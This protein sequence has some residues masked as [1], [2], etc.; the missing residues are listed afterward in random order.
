VYFL[1]FVDDGGRKPHWIFTGLLVPL[2][3]HR[4]F[5]AHWLKG[6]R[7]L[8][9]RWGVPVDAEIKANELVVTRGR[10]SVS[11]HPHPL[12][13]LFDRLEAYR[14]M[15]TAVADC[16]TLRVLVTTRYDDG[17][18]HDSKTSPRDLAYAEFLRRL[19]GWAER[20]RASVILIY[21]GGP[22]PRVADDTTEEE[23]LREW[24]RYNNTRPLRD[25]YEHLRSEM[26]VLR[27]G[28]PVI[29]DML[30][31]ESA[32]SPLIQAADFVSFAAFQHV[33]QAHGGSP[34]KSA[35]QE[36]L[37]QYRRKIAALYRSSMQDRWLPDDDHGIHWVGYP[38]QKPSG[39]T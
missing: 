31:Q 1:C 22:P 33:R 37:E 21:D 11:T 3:D 10:P 36:R 8:A 38:I 39:S 15:L 24:R 4:T 17:R 9:N 26:A 34:P 27:D 32:E 28:Q 16:D 29:R 18:T 23:F 2:G 12:A 25:V 20:A 6:R 5:L 35:G 13:S 19:A 7:T 14:I 30:L